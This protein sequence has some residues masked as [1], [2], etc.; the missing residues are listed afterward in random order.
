[1]SKMNRSTLMIYLSLTKVEYLFELGKFFYPAAFVIVCDTNSTVRWF[2]LTH[3]SWFN[4][5][6]HDGSLISR[7]R[8][9]IRVVVYDRARSKINIDAFL[10]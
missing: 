7:N 5:K 1:M 3:D 10:E 9:G 2:W 8:D 4:G 6:W